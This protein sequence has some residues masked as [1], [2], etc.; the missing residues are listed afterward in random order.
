MVHMNNEKISSTL[1]Q[2]ADLLEFT[3]AN[4][5]RLRAYR[6]GAR[7]IRELPDSIASLIAD[8]ADLTKLEG[9]GKGV[10]E[11]CHELVE[12]GNLTQ[13]EEIL[14]TVPRTVLDLLNV[15]KLGPKKAAALFNELGIENL[16][17]LKTACEA[18]EVRNLAGFGEKTESSILAGI[19]I[20]EAA[21]ERILWAEADKI[22]TRLREHMQQCKSLK[23]LEF[24]GSYRRGKETVGDLD[25]LAVSDDP[26]SVMDHLA[27]FEEITSDIVRGE[28]KMAVRLEDEFQIDLRVVPAESFGAALQYFTGSK[29]HNVIVRGRAKKRGLRV[30]EWGVYQVEGDEQSLIAGKTETEVYASLGLPYFEPEIREARREFDWADDGELPTLI[31]LSD[32]V[33]DLHMH[34]T[35]TDGKASIEEMADAA[36]KRGLKFIAITDHSKRVTMANGLD[37]ERLMAQWKEIDSINEA[38]TDDFLILKGIECDILESGGMDLPDNVL[39]LADWVIASVHYGQNQSRQQITDRITGAIANPH[40][41]MVAHPTGRLLNKRE[42]YDVDLEAVFS[43]AKEHGKL[44]ELNA[45]PRRLDLNDIHLIAAASHGIPIVINTDAHRIG[46]LEDMRFGIKQAR[47]GCLTATNVANTR[48]WDE[49]KQLIGRE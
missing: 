31:E 14:E 42:P 27:L 3:G 4:A 7:I 11:K 44:L 24:A 39:A 29:D 38:A 10:A 34:T 5:F 40:V 8:K 35:A 15:P 26:E 6:N 37:G 23:Q 18:G 1:S 33:G 19:A 25:M 46:G 45:N 28:T 12:T 9:I 21:N 30:N 32:I 36:R 13:L 47:R 17:Q 43:A 41:S 2:L 22:V 20:A 49:M 16:Q 48:S